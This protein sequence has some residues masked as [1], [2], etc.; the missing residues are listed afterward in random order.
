MCNNL[1][2]T[3]ARATRSVSVSSL[4]L[5]PGVPSS[6]IDRT[7]SLL[8]RCNYP[9]LSYEVRANPRSSLPSAET[10]STPRTL[11]M[12]LLPSLLDLPGW[13]W[14]LTLSSSRRGLKITKPVRLPFPASDSMSV[15]LINSQQGRLVHVTCKPCPRRFSFSYSRS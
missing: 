14:S 5:E 8:R 4:S 9:F 13:T 1:C 12:V 10:L 6:R 15:M 2:Y 3:Y 11:V 7:G